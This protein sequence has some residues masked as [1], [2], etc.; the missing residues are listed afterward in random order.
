MTTERQ[1]AAISFCE[2]CLHIPFT[3]DKDDKTQVSAYLSEYLSEA[4]DL[5]EEIKGDYEAYIHDKFYE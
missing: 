1:K 5:F 2:E 4:K 3:G